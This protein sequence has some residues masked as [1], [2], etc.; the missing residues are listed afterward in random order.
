MDISDIA[1]K[2]FKHLPVPRQQM[3]FTSTKPYWNRKSFYNRTRCDMVRHPE[4]RVILPA[5]FWFCQ[6]WVRGALKWK[7]WGGDGSD[8]CYAEEFNKNPETGCI[9]TIK[10]TNTAAHTSCSYRSCLVQREAYKSHR[11]NPIN[12]RRWSPSRQ[13]APTQTIPFLDNDL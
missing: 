11:H 8:A 7:Y 6:Q 4:L 9:Q 10:S 1:S 12:L 2:I 3:Q 13:A 5:S